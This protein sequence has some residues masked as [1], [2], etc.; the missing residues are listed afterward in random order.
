MNFYRPDSENEELYSIM[1]RIKPAAKTR[2]VSVEGISGIRSEH[3]IIF[4]NGAKF[5]VV[6]VTRDSEFDRGAIIYLEEK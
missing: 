5:R 2:G 6:K 1:Y 3:E 4:G